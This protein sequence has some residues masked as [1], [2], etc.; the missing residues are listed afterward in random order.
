MSL[1]PVIW[2]FIFGVLAGVLK[3]ELRLPSPI[4]EFVSMLLLITIGLKG[5]IEL[6]QQPF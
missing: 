1:D 2:F 6:A 3:S 4:Y 5:G